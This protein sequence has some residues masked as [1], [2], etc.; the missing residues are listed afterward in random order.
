M[1]YLEMCQK[2]VLDL[3]LT[4]TISTVVGQTGMSE[5]IVKW[6]ADADEDVQS[7]WADWMFL[8]TQFSV[9]TVAGTRQYSKPTDI[10]TWDLDSFYLNYTADTY[11][12]LR[13]LSYID[14]RQAYRQ[15]THTNAKPDM[16]VIT[17]A[18]NI[19]LEPIP[20]AAYTLTAD[21]W[22]TPTRMTLNTSTSAIPD[23]FQR[24]II[25]RAK[26][27]YAEHEE[28]SAVLDLANL[29]Y[30]DLLHKLESDQLPGKNKARKKSDN[31]DIRMVER[32]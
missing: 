7:E 6:V 8:W 13:E 21:Y 12:H 24:I 15:G 32:W 16:F 30:Q 19:Y 10:A 14:Y 9:A 11:Q 3:G 18:L 5:K 22:K 4:N 25:A 17:P 31:H 23:R 1:T 29:E 26:I 28:F 2:M 20:D 27:Y